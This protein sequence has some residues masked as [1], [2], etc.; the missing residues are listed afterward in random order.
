MF[1]CRNKNLNMKKISV[2]IVL[3]LPILLFAGNNDGSDVLKTYTTAVTSW[4]PTITSVAYKLFFIFAFFALVLEFGFKLLNNDIELGSIFASLVKIILIFGLFQA[5]IDWQWLYVIFSSF[6]KLGDTVNVSAGVSV[7]V[8]ADTL[9]DSAY[10]LMK[11][12]TKNVS[13]YRVDVYFIGLIAIISIV[14]LSVELITTYIKFLIMWAISP[15]FLAMGV[16]NHTRQWALSAITATISVSLEYMLIKLVIGLSLS[17]INIYAKKATSSDGSL[18]SL[19]IIVLIIFGLT[20]MVHGIVSS[21]FS[22]HLGA[23][24]NSGFQAAKQSAQAAMGGLVGGAMGAYSQ[25]KNASNPSVNTSQSSQSTSGNLAQ[26]EKSKKSK[27]A[28]V[29]VGAMAGAISGGVKGAFGYST[30]NAGNKSGK[31]VANMFGFSDNSNNDNDSSSKD[32][33][34]FDT[35]LINNDNLNGEIKPS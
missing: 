8:S 14:W 20:K 16:F 7:K 10:E 27:V 29:A 28:S 34:G 9:T 33:N 19:L 32:R 12:I 18:F 25:I 5:F 4:I 21:M 15:L 23:N 1:L 24:N 26:S 35:S 30:Y 11:A 22:G 17:T 2:V 31:G 6:D 3:F 13:W